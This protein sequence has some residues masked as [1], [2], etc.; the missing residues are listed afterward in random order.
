MMTHDG[1]HSLCAIKLIK[2]E[3]KKLYS[4]LRV[5]TEIDICDGTASNFKNRYQLQY[6]ISSGVACDGVGGLCKHYAT[7]LNLLNGSQAVTDAASV[8]MLNDMAVLFMYPHEPANGFKWHTVKGECHILL[9]DVLLKLKL[10]FPSGHS[11]RLHNF[12]SK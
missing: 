11:R 6:E 10:S 1:A 9:K 7:K 4:C 2:G 12:D 5:I 3:V 8:G